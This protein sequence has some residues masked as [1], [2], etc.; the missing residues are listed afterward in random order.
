MNQET[1]ELEWALN[2]LRL[3]AAERDASLLATWKQVQA[4]GTLARSPDAIAS[5]S[6]CRVRYFRSP[7]EKNAVEEAELLAAAGD[8]T[9]ARRL[10]NVRFSLNSMA[11]FNN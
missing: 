4:I 11:I 5:D 6:P 7:E 10:K 2:F 3:P 9:I 8:T 1:R